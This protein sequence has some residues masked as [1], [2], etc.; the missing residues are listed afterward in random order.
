MDTGLVKLQPNGIDPFPVNRVVAGVGA[1]TR[2]AAAHNTESFCW[3]GVELDEGSLAHLQ[4]ADAPT[5]PFVC[6]CVGLATDAWRMEF[7]LGDSFAFRA[8][9]PAILN[10]PEE[11][12]FAWCA[13]HPE[14]A[15]AFVAGLLP[16]LTNQDL[17]DEQR[18]MH[19]R[20]MRLLDE[21]GH[22]RD[23]LQALNRNVH[24]FG[25]SG[26]RANYYALYDEPL[27][28]LET[29]KHGALRRWAKTTREQLS[30]EISNARDEDDE[31]NAS[32]GI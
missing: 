1:D 13:A 32:W 21:F 2:H 31:Q 23:V 30:S 26:S 24:T 18:A 16:L 8:K 14:V 6:S 22:R 20:M 17:S 11:V 15:P 3:K 19:P 10:L 25:W 4:E 28:S 29:H 9:R 7:A 27:R 5:L 12:M